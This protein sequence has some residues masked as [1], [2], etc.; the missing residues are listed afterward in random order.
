MSECKKIQLGPKE[1]PIR[2]DLNVVEKVQKRFDNVENLPTK[3]RDVKEMKWMLFELINEG[4][5]YEN[6]MS[7]IVAKHVTENEVGMLLGYK[8]LGRESLSSAILDAFNE[9][10]V[11][12]KNV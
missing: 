12:E 8:D 5:D 3:L 6:Y 11:D 10:M 4:I 7:G 1:F 9:C 2:F